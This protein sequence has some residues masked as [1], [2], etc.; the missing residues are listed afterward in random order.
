ML[1]VSISSQ[2]VLDI[3]HARTLISIQ[4]NIYLL[5]PFNSFLQKRS[6]V[7]VQKMCLPMCFLFLDFTHEKIGNILKHAIYAVCK[8]KVFDGLEFK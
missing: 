5:Y 2:C 6:C 8:N 7:I 1:D 3:S 4:Y